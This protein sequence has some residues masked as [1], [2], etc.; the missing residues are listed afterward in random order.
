MGYRDRNIS[1]LLENIVF[2]E[3]KRRGFRVFTG[4]SEERE[5]D[6]IAT[7]GD[8]KV[9]VQVAFRMEAQSTIDREFSPLLEIRDH[10]TKYVVTMDDVWRDNIEGIHHMHIADFL[11]MN[12]I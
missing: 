10:H 3:L 6:F 2:L 9:Y 11:L 12:T 4:R 7:S 1:G 5:I 8:K